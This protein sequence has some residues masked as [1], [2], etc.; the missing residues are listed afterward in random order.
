MGDERVIS[1]EVVQVLR[2]VALGVREPHLTGAGPGGEL[3]LTVDGWVLE[4]ARDGEGLSHCQRCTAPDG[5]VGGAEHWQ[6][7]GT[8]PLNLL[9]TWELQQLNRLL[10]A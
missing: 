1:R 8:G 10:G 5:R 6:R 4:L 2:D 9:S 7:Y 3:T